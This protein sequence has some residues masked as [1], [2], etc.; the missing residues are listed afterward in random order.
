MPLRLPF[1]PVSPP[2]VVDV[3]GV[4]AS[5]RTRFTYDL[6]DSAHN[7]KK[8]L[9]GVEPGGTLKW[10]ASASVKGTGTIPLVDVGQDVDWLNDRI[11]V[12]VH[13]MDDGRDEVTTS[14]GVYLPAAPVES[15]K[16]G[17]RR[18]DVE[19]A[20]RSS[21]LDQ[22]IMTS[23]AGD[24]VTFTVPKGKC[25]I[26]AI[27]EIIADAGEPEPVVLGDEG[28]HLQRD[29]TWDMETT[30]LQIINDLLDAGN[31]LSLW[32]DG[33]GH[34]QVSKADRPQDR[35][36]LYT[37]WGPLL[38]G[39]RSVYSPEW[40]HDRDI[41][42]VPNRLLA[43]EEGDGDEEG[44]AAIAINMDP[45]S[46]YSFPNRDGRWVT[47]VLTGTSVTA[48]EGALQQWAER[49]LA[50]MTEVTSKI[51]VEH[52]FLPLLRPNA[53]IRFSGGDLDRVLTRVQST[54]V[55]LESTSMVKTD[56]RQVVETRTEEG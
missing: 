9:E 30:R 46:P 23:A 27:R 22:D 25:I 48:A 34:F 29:M 12:Q 32:V 42:S 5:R 1:T 14:L 44:D 41:Y 50:S 55:R 43:I 20:D 35:P 4:A 11:R 38:E 8:R 49:R 39:E 6:L 47:E 18:W 45:E 3:E 56:L 24:P 52:L 2:L 21:V 7:V 13:T 19:L 37:M 33:D 54:E 17:Q 26:R 53:V 51:E 36:E 16:D 40:T 28:A 10:T 15:W 31:F